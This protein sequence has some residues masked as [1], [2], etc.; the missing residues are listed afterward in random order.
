M[1]DEEDISTSS[2]ACFSACLL[3]RSFPFLLEVVWTVW[4][5]S[6]VSVWLDSC[7]P[8]GMMLVPSLLELLELLCLLV[9]IDWKKLFLA[10]VILPSFTTTTTSFFSFLRD[11][12]L[13]TC[14]WIM[15]FTKSSNHYFS[16]PGIFSAC[17]HLNCFQI[18]LILELDLALLIQVYHYPYFQMHLF[19]Q[20]LFQ[21]VQCLYH[22]LSQHLPLH[23]K[24]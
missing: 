9:I 10:S 11:W 15:Q 1:A 6:L 18:F 19:S 12:F 3:K 24:M 8:A 23:L 21:L 14:S 4:L 13:A 20:I 2:W 22:Q 16:I 7:I 17:Q 5:V